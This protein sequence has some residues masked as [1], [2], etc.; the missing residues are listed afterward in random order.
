MRKKERIEDVDFYLENIKRKAE[1]K[2]KLKE[3]KTRK[4]WR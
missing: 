2:R 1:R 3:N 4:R